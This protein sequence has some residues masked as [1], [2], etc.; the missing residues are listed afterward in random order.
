MISKEEG[1]DLDFDATSKTILDKSLS[2]CKNLKSN[3]LQKKHNFYSN[4]F[5]L[6]KKKWLC[7]YRRQSQTHTPILD[8]KTWDYNYSLQPLFYKYNI[9]GINHL[10]TYMLAINE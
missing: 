7:L 3:F 9:N 8:A 6:T 5:C 1:K 4:V 2:S 10:L